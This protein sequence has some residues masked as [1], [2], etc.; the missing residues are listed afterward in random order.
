MNT[1]KNAAV[2]PLK[3][4]APPA[5]AQPH[6][7]QKPQQAAGQPH[8]DHKPQQAVAQPGASQPKHKG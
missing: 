5:Q 3:S 7:A 1:P 4:A 6:T 8:A 2:E